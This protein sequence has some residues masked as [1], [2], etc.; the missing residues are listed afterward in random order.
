MRYHAQ[1]ETFIINDGHITWRYWFRRVREVDVKKPAPTDAR[2]S[3]DSTSENGVYTE[4]GGEAGKVPHHDLPCRILVKIRG[5]E[6]FV[7]NRS[8]VYDTVLA[9]LLQTE[10][11]VSDNEQGS[12]RPE[13]GKSST[14]ASNGEK[15]SLF[16]SSEKGGLSSSDPEKLRYQSST[17]L[18]SATNSPPSDQRH[19]IDTNETA[20]PLPSFLHLLPIGVECNRGAV[21]VGNEHTRCVLVTK[22]NSAKGRIDA[23]ASG[24][25]D[26]YRQS[27]DF[28]IEKPFI[29]MKPN[30]DY[31][32]HQ[33]VAGERSKNKEQRQTTV[34]AQPTWAARF[35]RH[36]QKTF[37]SLHAM[38]PFLRRSV[39]SLVPEENKQGSPNA[40]QGSLG[41]GRWLG[42]SRYLDDDDV[43]LE[44]ERWKNIEYAQVT[45]LVDC[46]RIG[47]SFFWDIPGPVAS[48]SSR[49]SNY[50]LSGSEDDINGSQP[51]TWG[52]DL[53]IGGGLINYGPWADRQRADLQTVFFPSSYTDAIIA[54]P[55]KPGESRMSTIFKIVIILDEAVVLRIHTR[56]ESKDWKWKRQLS[57]AAEAEKQRQ[58]QNSKISTAKNKINPANTEIRPP[59]WLEI[60]VSANTCVSYTMDMVAHDYGY[61]NLLE[62]DIKSPI[63]SSSVNHDTLLRAGSLTMSCDL[64]N[65]LGWKSLRHWQFNVHSDRLELFILRDHAFLMQDLVGDWT[66]GPPSEFLTFV[67]FLYSLNLQLPNFKVYLNV[68]DSNIINNASSTEDNT[69][70]VIW[71]EKLAASLAIPIK[72]FRPSKNAVSFDIDA[73]SGGLKFL[74]PTWNTQR[75][76]L[77]SNDVASLED[78]RVIGSYNYWTS[79]SPNL[80][81]TVILNIHGNAP[82]VQLYGFIIRYFMTF[83]DNYF[84]EDLH[85][86]TL[87]EY[88][89]LFQDDPPS[90]SEAEDHGKSK[91]TNDLDVILTLTADDVS[92]L[93]PAN[94][95]S[96]KE[97]VRI[98]LSTVVIDLR[99]TN[100]YM[101]IEVSFSP[102]AIT[103]GTPA[104]DEGQNESTYSSTQAFVDGAVIKGHRLFGLPPTEPTYVCNWDFDIGKVSGECSLELLTTLATAA[105]LLAFEFVDAENK[106]PRRSE[107]I[108]HDI[109][110]LRARVEPIKIWLHVQTSAFLFSTDSIRLDFNDWAGERFSE[111]LHLSIPGLTIA[112]VD[113]RSASRTRTKAHVPVITHAYIQTSVDLRM[114][115]S[116]ADFSANK[117]LQ[118][119]WVRLHD[120]RTH[121]TPWLLHD[122]NA[123][124]PY[125]HPDTRA[126]VR[127][128]AMPYPSMPDPIKATD[129]DLSTL[130]PSEESL[131]ATTRIKHKSSFLS[132]NSNKKARL[133]PSR[134]SGT[135][136]ST[137]SPHIKNGNKQSPEPVTTRSSQLNDETSARHGESARLRGLPPVSV[138]FSSPFEMPYFPLHYIDPDTRDVPNVEKGHEGSASREDSDDSIESV[139][140]LEDGIKYTTFMIRF[141]S[142]IRGFCS[143]EA[144]SRANSLISGL[145]STDPESLLDGLQIDSIAGVISKSDPRPSR[146]SL[147]IRV[148]VPLAAIRFKSETSLTNDTF[149]DHQYYDLTARNL[150]VTA[151][152]G[153]TFRLE[154]GTIK[155]QPSSGYAALDIINLVARGTSDPDLVDHARIEL[156][157]KSTTAWFVQEKG[158]TGE[159]NS[160][161]I[162]VT[163]LNRKVEN[164][165]TLVNSTITLIQTLSSEFETTFGSSKSR[166]RHLVFTLATSNTDLPDPAFL[167]SASYFLR[168]APHHVRNSD[169]W[170]MISRLRLIWASLSDE[171]RNR[172]ISSVKDNPQY[173]SDVIGQVTASFSQWRS[174]DLVHIHSSVFMQRVFKTTSVSVP[175]SQALSTFP[176]KVAFKVDA[177]RFVV[178]PGPEQNE[179]EIEGLVIGASSTRSHSRTPGS[180]KTITQD[181]TLEVLCIK[182]KLHLTWDICEL[183]EG[184]VRQLTKANRDRRNPTPAVI[185]VKPSE[186]EQNFNFMLS[187]ED[188]DITL[189]TINLTFASSSSGLVSSVVAQKLPSHELSL[190]AVLS[191]KFITS[192]L[193]SQLRPVLITRLKQPN[194]HGSL[195]TTQSGEKMTKIWKAGALCSRLE[196]ELR[197]DMLGILGIVDLLLRDEVGYIRN[198]GD[199]FGD[200]A[201][202][203]SDSLSNEQPQS[204]VDHR[205]YAA[206]LLEEYTISMTLFSSL[207]YTINGRVARSSWESLSTSGNALAIGFDL[208]RHQ[209]T[210]VNEMNDIVQEISS[211]LLPPINGHIILTEEETSVSMVVY[212]ALEKVLLDASAIHALATTLSRRELAAFRDNVNRDLRLVQS[213]YK[214]LFGAQGK[215]PQKPNASGSLSSQSKNTFAYHIHVSGAG[216]NIRASTSKTSNQ[217]ARLLFEI[218]R[219]GLKTTNESS[220]SK[221][222]LLFPEIKVGV[223][224]IRVILERFD[225]QRSSPCGDVTLG[226]NF[227]G[228]SKL[229]EHNERSRSFEVSTDSLEVNIFP[230]TAS[231]IVDI[232]GYVQQ[233]F[234]NFN[235]SEEI[236]TLRARRLRSKS[237]AAVLH[238]GGEPALDETDIPAL[239]F[240]SMYSLDINEIQ[241]AWRVGELTPV[242]PGHEIED[243]VFSIA[244]I[245][246]A[247]KKANAAQLVIRDLQLQMVPT[248]KSTK[249]RSQNSA[250]LPEVVF[251]VAYLSSSKDRRLAFQAVGKSVDL[252]LT[253]RFLLPANDIQ[254]SIA[255]ATQ[256]LRKVVADWNTSFIQDE[257]QNK[258]LLGNKTLSSVLVD[259]D[260]AGAVVYFQGRKIAQPRPLSLA[261]MRTDRT[262]PGQ[263]DNQDTTSLR[264]P[265]IAFKIEYQNLGLEDPSLNAEIKIDASTNILYPT[266]VPLILEA[267]ASFKEI[268]GEQEDAEAEQDPKLSPTKAVD[269]VTL[270][271]ADPSAI[272]G[273]VRLN[274]GLRI[275]RQEFGLSCQPIA[276]VAASA[277]F[278]DIY[279]TVNTVQAPDQARFFALSAV[280]TKLQA[281]VQHVYSREST[282]SFNVESIEL[283][284]MNSKHVSD[285]NGLSAIL[286]VSPMEVIINAKQLHDFMLFREIWI[287]MEMRSAPKSPTTTSPDQS[288]FGVQR[289]QQVAAV[290]VFPWTVSVAI[291]QLDVKVDL[292]QALGK[293]SFSILNLWVSSKKLTDWEQNLCLGFDKV[294]IDCIGRL[295]CAIE[296]KNLRL[297]TSI[298]WPEIESTLNNT[299]LI[300]ASL[301]FDDFRV[302]TAFEYQTFLIADL[303][304]LE[305]LMYNVRDE[306]IFVADRLVCIVNSDKV[307]MYC[308]AQSAAQGYALY[309]AIQRLV[310]EKRLAYENALRDIET[311]HQRKALSPMTT[312]PSVAEKL[313]A[314]PELSKTPVRL[315]TKVVVSLKAL[316]I[317]AYPGTFS[318]AQIFKL[319]ALDASARFSV[320]FEG[321]KLQSDLGLTLG[322]VRIALSS[323]TKRMERK[324]FEDISVDE[325]IT[326]S[327]G[328]RG[329]TILKVPRVVAVMRT[330]QIP[331]STQIEYIF[332]SSFEGKVEVGWNYSRISFIRGM[333]ANHTRALAHRL[334]K[335]L[336]QSA[337]QIKGGPQPANEEGGEKHDAGEEQEKITAVVNV[338]LSK[339][340][341]TAI[342]PPVIET[343]QLRDMGEATPPLEWI[344]LHRDRLPNVTHQIVIVPLLEVAKEVEDAYSK[345]LGTS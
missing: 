120:S 3:V 136:A 199:V 263:S 325:V 230:E 87:E 90:T 308:T 295:S 180:K 2:S 135:K 91:I 7:Y 49:H 287:P 72:E 6:W 27:F 103:L 334:G 243:L 80:T 204:P 75:V 41:T 184:V 133:S 345:I 117:A 301:G 94:L 163:S 169:S 211:L 174:W 66:A 284:L 268:V 275:C 155:T 119:E 159:I 93:L 121:R 189:K 335:A 341:Y 262:R 196:F 25:E 16:F 182:T 202:K 328:S 50:S 40:K 83:K 255:I 118:Q 323:V 224:D 194:L 158:S 339:Y 92:A 272:L 35:R 322:Q 56:E 98:D 329:G 129:I 1:N 154:D 227:R 291:T 60:A 85:F 222:I 318:D 104:T 197:E 116:K 128:P 312:L 316:N 206:L 285:V 280:F 236:N 151:R 212:L 19:G 258:K 203:E 208:K 200:I 264:T 231:M 150:A 18:S 124:T 181:S 114:V 198:L 210:F 44:Q 326:C 138:T 320:V 46:S 47:M 266:I 225:G 89:Q 111:R 26:A 250:L 260:F 297:R 261:T 251:N 239:L 148:D 71:G 20:P 13:K 32:E 327:I 219:V 321:Q 248:S 5:L 187:V 338:P 42:L 299:P 283:S 226:I 271:S 157:L 270:Q 195:E 304:S 221:E 69:F 259:A 170:K 84:G 76:F 86:Q 82:I 9:S 37:H 185:E 145:L 269:E 257:Q 306:D 281:S 95:Y 179:F 141:G 276:K 344:G 78:V 105:R 193:S 235:L 123:Y 48:R 22:F 62:L 122:S 139:P 217:P 73:S 64:S 232:L 311:Y 21:V 223:K 240:N 294:G 253:S 167:T 57:T 332:S 53:K 88:Q 220:L 23:R 146:E 171:D 337:V 168:T 54:E 134:G 192:A 229:N 288:T 156:S 340:S 137:Y 247:T 17:P 201:S 343:P 252:R 34:E 205:L 298:H 52:L 65:P 300:Q 286:K 342:E 79:T 77:D 237:Q 246:L 293:S 245:N 8:P 39:E 110:F 331:D 290:G 102:L 172:L 314:D 273:D 190:T 214:A 302:K 216:M 218:G 213:N 100:Y 30:Q 131:G 238:H 126:K 176:I 178:D 58:G 215:A 282:G 292:G 28:E 38:I 315:Q 99:F 112:S 310:Q 115:E 45:T 132:I 279:V 330:W 165:V 183:L 125:M 161:G 265:G 191:A 74:T 317:G 142:G 106:V 313:E 319:E 209:H 51:P 278:E 14:E 153:Y 207:R 70:F 149:T 4:S 242:S 324:I 36:K 127:P 307:Q 277:Q 59:G 97:N 188:H 12:A 166:L 333:W 140:M 109:T 96:A 173:P 336:P 234:K 249:V 61:R 244:K 108:L 143:P 241:V 113:S 303:S 233:R 160:Q 130:T 228:T 43:N 10:R 11:K 274:L 33:L 254:R 152:T 267:S 81:D 31:R 68:N 186:I 256:D 55:L 107:L 101:D 67:P 289:Y 177:I 164:L 309:Q 296:L 175:S 15:A 305:F 29:Q 144:I 162:E 24:P 63:I 147:Q